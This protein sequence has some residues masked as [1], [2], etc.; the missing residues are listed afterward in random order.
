MSSETKLKTGEVMTT[1]VID[2]PQDD[3]AASIQRLLVHKG[4]PWETHIAEW[5]AGNIRKLET[6]FYVGEIDGVLVANIMTI[7]YRGI[8]IMGHVFTDPGHRKK[9][10]CDVLM[11]LHME[12]FRDRDGIVMC[13]GTWYRSVPYGIY[14]RHGYLATPGRPGSMWWSPRKWDADTR[15]DELDIYEN[16]PRSSIEDPQWHHWPSMNVFTQIPTKQTVR[17]FT[18]GLIGIQQS[19]H[20]YLDLFIN[21]ESDSETNTQVKILETTGGNVAGLASLAPDK[22]W[23]NQGIT[24]VF[25]AFVHPEA[26]E[27]IP[28][29]A[30]EFEWPDAHVLTYVSEEDNEV[31]DQLARAGF[32]PHSHVE[33]FFRDDTGLIIM[34]RD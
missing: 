21:L 25:D 2:D 33:R 11:D 27:R 5:A 30:D 19:E 31:I 10:I 18:F 22:R 20:E 8:G 17:N 34:D 24:W 9:G 16:L 23:R 26:L 32:K 28:D 4:Q 6:R 13:L 1:R 29:L 15:F 3:D 14:E 12:D 7:E